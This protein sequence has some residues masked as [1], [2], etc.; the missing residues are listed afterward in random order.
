MSEEKITYT[1]EEWKLP[2]ES[3]FEPEET[4]EYCQ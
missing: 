3:T 1:E 4:C 2:E